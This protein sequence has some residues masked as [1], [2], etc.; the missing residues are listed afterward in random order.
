MEKPDSD[1]KRIFLHKLKLLRRGKKEKR[2]MSDKNILE[3][4][5]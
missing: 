4:Q 1:A 2:I 3:R 5:Q